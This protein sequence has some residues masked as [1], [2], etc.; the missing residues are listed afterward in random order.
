M[1]DGVDGNPV[2]ADRLYSTAKRAAINSSTCRV[3][4]GR[5]SYR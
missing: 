2:R 1:S 4:P 3:K 5:A